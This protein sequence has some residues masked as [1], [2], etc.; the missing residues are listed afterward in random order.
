M[1]WY[2]KN[3]LFATVL[4]LCVIVALGELAFTYERFR[5]SRAAEKKLKEQTTE[6]QNMSGITPPPTREVAEAIEADLK[7]AQASLAAMQNELK[8]HGPAAERLVAAKAPPGRPEAYFDLASYVEKMRDIAKKNDVVIR[9]DAARLGFNI[10]V[11]EGPETERIEPVFRQRLIAQYL[12]ESL[13]EAKP[14]AISAVKRERP[15]TK[16]EREARAQAMANGEVPQ[17]DTSEDSADYFTIDPRRTARVAGYVD[18]TAFR[19]TF[20]GQ[21]TALRTFLN[22]LASFELPMLVREVEVETA[23]AEEAAVEPTEE[24][25]PAEQPAAAAPTNVAPSVVLS[26]DPA[27]AAAP[28][29]A[30]KPRVSTATPIVSKPLSKYTVTVE[31][32]ELVSAQPAPDGSAP[33]KPPTE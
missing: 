14:K 21:T 17:E 3:P 31:Y 18:A 22:K 25:A 4:T 26:T 10:Y 6:L 9:P 29:P 7:K 20:L 8:G 24:P 13:L 1:S 11:N 2:R 5:A 16:A 12:M 23:T 28:K 30:P 15:M 32:I 33:A 27:P 19:I